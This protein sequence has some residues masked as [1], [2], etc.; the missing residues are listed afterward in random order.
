MGE[1]GMGSPAKLIAE[2]KQGGPEGECS[3]RKAKVAESQDGPGEQVACE[4]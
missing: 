4:D 1:R 2:L 3:A